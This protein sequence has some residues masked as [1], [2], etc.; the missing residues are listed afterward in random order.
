MTRFADQYLQIAEQ[1]ALTIQLPVVKAIHIDT[2]PGNPNKSSKFGALVLEDNSVGLTYVGLDQARSELQTMAPFDHFVGVSPVEVARLYTREHSWQRA[3]GM[4]AINAISQHLLRVSNFP[5][6][7]TCGTMDLLQPR[8]GDRIGM[9]GYFP[10][11]VK[12]IRD[13]KLPLTVIELD[14]QWVQREDRFEVTLDTSRLSRCNKILCTGTVLINQT[15]ENILAY[16]TKATRIIQIGPT[17]GCLPDPLF[18]SGV[19]AVGGRQVM[20][21]GRFVEL[22]RA[23]EPWREVTKRYTISRED[24]S[25]FEVLLDQAR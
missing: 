20:D 15:L 11:L 24:Y 8:I 25:G 1:I 18:G 21:Y 16:T 6:V 19:T 3:L 23:G 7:E 5:L 14:P 22:W 13:K 17:V 9:V 12:A 4:A 10:P 2:E